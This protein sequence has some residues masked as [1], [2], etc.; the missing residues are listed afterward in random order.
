MTKEEAEAMVKSLIEAAYHINDCD[1][2]EQRDYQVGLTHDIGANLIAA[3]T[4]KEE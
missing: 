1:S 4:G 2:H 3:L